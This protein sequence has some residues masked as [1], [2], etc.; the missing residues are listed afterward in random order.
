[1]GLVDWT[2]LFPL[3]VELLDLAEGSNCV[4]AFCQSLGPFAE[5]LLCLE[6]L[7][8]VEVAELAVDLH[9]IIERLYIVAVCLIEVLGLGG[10]HCAGGTPA[11]LKLP[12]C[13][14]CSAEVA[15]IVDEHL[16]LL[17][18]LA[19]HLEV[20]FFL[21]VQLLDIFNSDGLVLAVEIFEPSLQFCERI[22]RHFF[23][24]LDG[25]D[26]IGGGFYCVS[27]DLDGS[28]NGVSG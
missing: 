14:I 17:D 23:A 11:V 1:M 21:L 10:R 8:E 4:V 19:L 12:E 24:F 20:L 2:V 25:L 18:N 7:L 5:L 26:L 9:I 3:V 6:I 22:G 28:L 16:E 15:G 27:S 13:G